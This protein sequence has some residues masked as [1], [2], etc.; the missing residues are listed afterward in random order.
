MRR[1]LAPGAAL[2]GWTELE[3]GPIPGGGGSLR[4]VRRDDEYLIVVAGMELMGSHRSG[5]ERELAS[6]ACAALRDRASPRMLIGGLGMGFTLRAALEHLPERARVEVAE[7]VPAV[8]AW[9]RGPLAEVFG[10]ILDDARV[11]L[12]Q[13]DVAAPI[14]AARAAYDAILLDVDNGPDGLTH[15]GNDRLYDHGGLG[16]A[17]AALRPGGLL[18][19]WSAHPDPAFTRRLRDAGFGVEEVPVRANGRRGGARHRIWLATR[20]GGAR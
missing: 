8:A 3:T 18:A 20:P 12:V 11:R 13:T 1:S 10:G 4:L 17:R 2:A 15:P 16:L 5:S 6:L 7:L 14:A 19:V 9:A